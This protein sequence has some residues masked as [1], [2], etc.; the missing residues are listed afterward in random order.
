[1][2]YLLLIFL[3][4][5]ISSCENE[6]KENFKDQL[7]SLKT[8]NDSLKNIISE[9]NSKY[10]FDSISFREIYSKNNKYELNADFEME[11]LVVAYNPKK[12]YFI[13]YDSIVNNKKVN[14]DTLEQSNGG[15]KYKTKLTKEINDIWIEMNIENE[16]GKNRKAVLLE[17]I[18]TKN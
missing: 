1:M 3:L 12:S 5:I 17:T 9:I 4:L 15:F 11:I 14:A 13:K 8:E 10:V 18:S 2:K 16:F 7:E 6:K